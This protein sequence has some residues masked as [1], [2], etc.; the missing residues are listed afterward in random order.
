MKK[1]LIPGTK[2]VKVIAGKDNSEE[3]LRKD[4]E[5]IGK[6]ELLGKTI[7]SMFSI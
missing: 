5:K 3:K 7:K 6:I 2:I 1:E 4:L